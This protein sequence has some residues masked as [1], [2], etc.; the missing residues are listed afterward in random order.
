MITTREL[1][2]RA[3]VSQEY[4]RRLCAQGMLK[5]FKPGRDWFIHEEEADKFLRGRQKGQTETD[6]KTN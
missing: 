6:N 1:A 5:A 2:E 4:I 3:G